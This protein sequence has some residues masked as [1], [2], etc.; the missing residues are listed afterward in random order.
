MDSVDIVH[1]HS[2]Q[3]SSRT[4]ST[5]SMDFLQTGMFNVSLPFYF[6]YCGNRRMSYAVAMK[7]TC[8]TR[9]SRGFLQ[10]LFLP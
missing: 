3:Y 1:G 10:V 2:F 5:E 9:K 4:M 8:F 7:D 6:T